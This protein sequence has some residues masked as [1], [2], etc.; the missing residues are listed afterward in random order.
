MDHISL[1]KC[2]QLTDSG[3]RRMH[4]ITQTTLFEQALDVC[5]FLGHRGRG[6]A[7]WDEAEVCYAGWWCSEGSERCG[8]RGGV[9]GSHRIISGKCRKWCWTL[10]FV[11]WFKF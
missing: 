2:I 8:V 7:E 3:P 10:L 5:D 11:N 6:G 9:V 1:H 4:T